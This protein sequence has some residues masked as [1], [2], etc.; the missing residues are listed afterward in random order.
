MLPGWKG[1]LGACVRVSGVSRIFSSSP[2]DR[3]RYYASLATKRMG[4]GLVCRNATGSILLVRQTY[5][6]TWEIPG[7]SVEAD[8]S[9][10][11]ARRS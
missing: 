11:A 2:V 8:E 3:A 1:N 7:G 6:P 4:A 9:P 5:K 10:A